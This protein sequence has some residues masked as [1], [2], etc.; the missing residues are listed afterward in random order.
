MGRQRRKYT[1]EF[2][3]EA[4][5]LALKSPSIVKTASELGIP[6]G[7]LHNWIEI[8]KGHSVGPN[9]SNQ[10]SGR[11]ISDLVE[12]NRRLHKEL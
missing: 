3:Q 11:S 10:S 5:T 4:V 2:Q 6:V 9:K 1:D 8:F 12:E 7:T